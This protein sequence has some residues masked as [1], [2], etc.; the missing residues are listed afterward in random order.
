MSIRRFRNSLAMAVL[1]AAASD[2]GAQELTEHQI[3]NTL[4]QVTQAAPAVDVAMLVQEVTANMGKGV[5]NLPNWSQLANLAQ[6]AVRSTSR[7]TPSQS[8]PNPIERS[9]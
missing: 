7:T 9:A 8:N 5:A 6:L 3:I 2:A 4:G 1:L